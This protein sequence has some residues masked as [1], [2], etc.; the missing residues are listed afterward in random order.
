MFSGSYIIRNYSS[1][2]F[3]KYLQ[4]HAESEQLKPSGR[5]VSAQDLSDNIGRPGFAPQK[6]LLLPSL[7]QHWS[8]TLALPLSPEFSVPCWRVWSIRGIAVRGLQQ[9]YS[10]AACNGSRRRV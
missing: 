2:D 3:D 8:A 9:N 10:P 6:D 7:M 1:D 5:F 4:L